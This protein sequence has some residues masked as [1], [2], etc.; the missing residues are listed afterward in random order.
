[1]YL[2][3][4]WRGGL[5][6]N[7]CDNLS[8]DVIIRRWLD[9]LTYEKNCSKHTIIAYQTDLLS[10]IAFYRGYIGKPVD[11]DALKNCS[12]TDFRAWLSH[13]QLSLKR[14]KVSSRRA[15]SVLKSFF[16]FLSQEEIFENSAILRIKSPK[17][18]QTIPRSLSVDE[19][20]DTVQQIETFQNEE[21]VGKRDAAVLL[22][23]YGAGLRISEALNLNYK[24]RPC[25]GKVLVQGKGNKERYL[26]VLQQVE[27][28]IEVYIKE[29]PYGFEKET[30]L[31]LGVKGKR[32]QSGI[33]QK[34]IRKLRTALGLPENI[35]PHALR[36]SFAT[37]L[38]SHGTDLRTIQELLGHV[39]LSTTQKY[40]AVD[41]DT[42]LKIYNK[43][44]P[45]A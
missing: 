29:C 21:W 26:P 15:L 8:I 25:D 44:H 37:H 12:M 3:V 1:M 27:E 41:R 34:Q 43:A 7:P 22:L 45:R 23:L 40:T 6:N 14:K 42:M 17:V 38:L 19:A 2:K 4:V 11:L 39:S 20:L 10:F 32:L 16:R 35:T 18:P 36:H 9:W 28:A 30:P 24:D 31:F 33:V 5:Q 13:D